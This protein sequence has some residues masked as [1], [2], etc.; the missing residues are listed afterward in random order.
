MVDAGQK[1][2]QFTNVYR[3]F[4]NHLVHRESNGIVAAVAAGAGIGHLVEQLQ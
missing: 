1:G 2:Y 4:E 3:L